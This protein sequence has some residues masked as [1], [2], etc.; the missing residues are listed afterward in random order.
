MYDKAPY[1]PETVDLVSEAFAAAWQ[2]VRNQP[3]AKARPDATQYMIASVL[4][5]AVTDGE[6]HLDRLH[7]IAMGAVNDP[8]FEPR[9]TFRA[10]PWRH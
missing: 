4:L 8:L 2:E 7:Q 3:G 9:Q 5:D 10:F 6:L 1:D